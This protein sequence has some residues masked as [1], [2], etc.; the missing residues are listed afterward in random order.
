[1][2]CLGVGANRAIAAT[3]PAEDGQW[4]MPA[5]N[6]ASTRY[7]GLSEINTDNAK[8]LKVGFALHVP[9]KA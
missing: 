6:H 7:S 5:K 3:A 4:T 1:L 9:H 2:L 8:N